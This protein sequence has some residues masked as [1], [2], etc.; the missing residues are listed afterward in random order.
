M[1]KFPG[2]FQGKEFIFQDRTQ[3][4]FRQKQNESK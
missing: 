4:I 2:V 3:I 1:N